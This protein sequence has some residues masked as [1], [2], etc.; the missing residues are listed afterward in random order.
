[1]SA[2][3]HAL[4]ALLITLTFTLLLSTHLNPQPL[5][6]PSLSIQ[7]S[8]TMTQYLQR[9]IT[10]NARKRGCHLITDELLSHIQPDISTFHIGLIHIFIQHTSASLTLNEN[11]DSDVRLD[12]N[13]Q[14]DRIVPE[15]QSFRHDAEGDDDMPAHVKAS[16]MD[17]SVTV[18]IRGG[19][20]ALGTWQGVWLCEH[21]DSGGS[22]RVVVTM[23]GAVAEGKAGKAEKKDGR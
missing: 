12:M 22:R 6:T 5:T 2:T 17:S 23:H 3:L 15:S 8:T 20:L 16:L 13:D 1:M 7:P 21:R 18:P 14:L 4:L 9:S 10:L 11:A 19:R